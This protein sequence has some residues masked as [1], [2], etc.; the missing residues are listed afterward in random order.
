MYKDKDKQKQASK[1]RQR[2]Y[3]AKQKGVTSEGVTIK[4]V[5]SE[6]SKIPKAERFCIVAGASPVYN[7]IPVQYEHDKFDT[8]PAPLN[9]NDI[10]CPRNR[11]RYTRPDGTQYQ[12]DCLGKDFSL[13][14]GLLYQT[15]GDVR[16]CYA[17]PQAAPVD[18]VKAGVRMI[19]GP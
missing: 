18:E 3:R 7:R 13:T 1:A 5:T 9:P 12:F 8:R 11:G 15:I 4:G 6:Q 17:A 2:R 14:N 10:P 16:A 19:G